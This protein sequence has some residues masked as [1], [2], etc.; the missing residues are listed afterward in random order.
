MALRLHAIA[1]AD[2]ANEDSDDVGAPASDALRV[3][4]RELAAIVSEQPAF[5]AAE[6]TPAA[7]DAHRS[8]V[9]A[10]FKQGSVLPAPVGVVFRAADVLTR[11]MEL[12]YVSLTAA[13]EYVDDRA[14]ARV[15]V[16]RADGNA[17]ELEPDSDLGAQAAESTRAMRRRAVASIPLRADAGV[18]MELGAA[19]LVEREGWK[20][21]LASVSEQQDAHHLLRFTVTGPWAPYDFVRMQFGA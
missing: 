9:D 10:A 8:I 21:F 12:H 17:E 5:V 16:T 3:S 19:F 7:I 4:F 15:H 20:E 18:A 11:W 1:L 13:L 2:S 6:L 14:V